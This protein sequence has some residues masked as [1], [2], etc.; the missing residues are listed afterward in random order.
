MD[1]VAD[2]CGAAEIADYEELAAYWRG[3]ARLAARP[4][5]AALAEA[6][7]HKCLNQHTH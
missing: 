6:V 7:S 2:T 1:R 3:L 5:E 4:N